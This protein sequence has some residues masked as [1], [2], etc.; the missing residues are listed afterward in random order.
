MWTW[1]LLDAICLASLLVATLST[2]VEATRSKM[3]T[4][5]LPGELDNSNDP[6]RVKGPGNIHDQTGYLANINGKPQYV[7]YAEL[8]A[9]GLGDPRQIPNEVFLGGSE[10]GV[11]QGQF[12]QFAPNDRMPPYYNPEE[13]ELEGFLD[14]IKSSLS[15]PYLPMMLGFGA[16]ALSGVPGPG[17]WFSGGGSGSGSGGGEGGGGSL[18]DFNDWYSDEGG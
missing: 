1:R 12:M 3:A 5:Q 16:G 4:F 13:G 14:T 8:K 6:W 17:D 7:T 2:F 9:K 10:G 15:E 18:E 11:G